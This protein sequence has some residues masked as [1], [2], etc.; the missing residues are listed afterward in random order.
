MN[1][2]Y[3]QKSLSGMHEANGTCKKKV[4]KLHFSS[5][6]E[7]ADIKDNKNNSN[8]S[9]GA[10]TVYLVVVRSFLLI[11]VRSFVC[12][13]IKEKIV[14]CVPRSWSSGYDR[15][16][17][18]DGPGFNSRRTH[19]ALPLPSSSHPTSLLSPRLYYGPPVCPLGQGDKTIFG[20][21]QFLA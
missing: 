4:W 18:S 15:R 3:M 8:V 11:H 12:F 10:D 5:E 19:F 16:L 7:H 2:N 14:L 13:L 6:E 9:S 20:A 17:P 21:I 1:Q